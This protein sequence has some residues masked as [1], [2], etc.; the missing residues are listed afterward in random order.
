M[1]SQAARPSTFSK[2]SRARL[3][4]ARIRP[5]FFERQIAILFRSLRHHEQRQLP[6]ERFAAIDDA[7][8]LVDL[9]HEGA[10]REAGVPVEGR[11]E[12]GCD[13][14]TC[15]GRAIGEH[16]VEDVFP[17]DRV[18][19]RIP[20]DD[21]AEFANKKVISMFGWIYA[22]SAAKRTTIPGARNRS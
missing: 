9:V 4:T 3:R 10:A 14:E 6:A 19:E 18:V 13:G 20:A 17:A 2:S 7:E 22:D 16:V 15:V 5:F 8:A 21:C 12:V 1:P 11:K